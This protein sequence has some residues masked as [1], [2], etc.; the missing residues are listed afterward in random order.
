M[1]GQVQIKFSIEI[2]RIYVF[3][4]IIHFFGGFCFCFCRSFTKLPVIL[5]GIVTKED[6]LLAAKSGCKGIIVSNHGAR[7]LDSAPA[8]IEALPEVAKAVGSQM[9]VMLDGGIR[10]G[11]DVFKAIALGAQLV[12][13][14]R[15][16]LYGLAVNGQQGIEDVIGI[17]Q[18]EFDIAMALAGVSRVKEIN[19]NFVVHESQYAKCKL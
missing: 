12:L 5:K 4:I 15:P 19:E 10:T 14:G 6:A 1:A 3:D 11:T 7:Q 13:V 9:V 18:Q 8:T 16:V 2:A 17:L